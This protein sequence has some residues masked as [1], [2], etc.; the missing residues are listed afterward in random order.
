MYPNAVP[1]RSF[2]RRAVAALLASAALLL[3]SGG[4]HAQQAD[5]KEDLRAVI[6]AQ[7]KNI[8]VQ[9]KQ[10]QALTDAVKQLQT[11]QQTPAAA[12]AAATAPE[13]A[14]APTAAAAPTE[15]DVRK[16]IDD[17]LKTRDEEAKAKKEAEDAAKKEKL[18]CEGYRVGSDLSVKWA[19]EDGL[20]LW[21]RSPNDDFSMHIGGWFQYDQAYW[22][23]RTTL[24]FPPGARPTPAAQGVASGAALGGIGD[25]DDGFFWRRI[26]PLWEGTFWDVYEYRFNVALENDQFETTG[27]DEFW[28]GV[29]K[30]PYLGT[31]RVGHFKAAYGIEGDNVSSSRAM[32]FTERSSYSEAIELNQNFVTG[33]W[34]LNQYFDDRATSSAQVFR[35]DQAAATGSFFGDGQYGAQARLTALPIYDC[36]GRHLLHLGLSG[37]WRNGQSSTTSP[38][39]QFQLRARPE[40]RDDDPA[41]STGDPQVLPGANSNRMVDTGVMIGGSGCDQWIMGS[42]I[43][44]IR[45]PFSFQAEYGLNRVED[46]VG[47]G[48]NATGQKPSVLLA[49]P[50]DYV[51]HG[52]YA[53]VTYTLTGENRAYDRKTGALDRYYF[54]KKGPY[55]PFWLTQ[56]ED[57]CTTTGI[58]AIELAAR[59]T[60]VDLNDG[61]GVNR[62]NGGIMK[63]FDLGV[64]WYLNNNLNWIFEWV[65][66][67]RSSLPTPLKGAP[68]AANSTF[69]GWTSGLG[70]RIQM[71][72]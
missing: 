38:L 59:Y 30:L 2:R 1:R 55:T 67:D 34:L 36:D 49:A 46:I 44:Y 15:L 12:P 16:Y 18:A 31:L 9:Q 32:T 4:L 56:G 28:M 40:L 57:G 60:Y 19:F 10:I 24:R 54:G 71:S 69:P 37:G 25:L 29:N 68:T 51:F 8:E 53:Q 65:Y 42:E 5:T 48:I 26:R 7:Q 52:G 62:V 11:N 63:G 39:R 45:G 58:G 64:N 35:A 41:A 72:F 13:A 70:T 27:L 43:L 3:P 50:Q 14:T 33:A 17:A 22:N 6:E 20:F 61:L 47:F 21:A 23:Q 66:D